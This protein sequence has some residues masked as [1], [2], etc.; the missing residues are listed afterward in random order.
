LIPLRTKIELDVSDVSVQKGEFVATQL[1]GAVDKAPITYK[2]LQELVHAGQNR[3]SWLIF[4][5]GIEHAEHIAEQ[6]GAFG[7]D[8]APVHSK[9]PSE[10][11]D[12]AIKAFKSNELRAIVNYGKLTTGFNHPKIDLIGMLRPTLSVPLWVQML[13]RGTRLADGKDNCLVMDFARNTPRL[14]CI[15]D[16]RI[17]NKKGNKEGE[18]PIKICE[19]CGAYN[20]ISVRFCCQ[21]NEPFTFQ[22]KIISKAGT[23]ELIKAAV[24]EPT[25]IIETFSVLNAIY[26]KHQ[27]RFGKPPTLKTTYFTTGLAFKEYI[28]LEHNGMAGK[29]AR[30][31]WRRRSPLEPPK[32]VDEALEHLAKL[33]CP[34][35]IRVHVNKS[36]PEI[37]NA[38]F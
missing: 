7:I 5:S 35:F 24:T 30:D 14:G 31:W 10:Y 25:P 2:A 16:P 17:P 33:R 29:V 13:F 27:G 6:L 28:C 12:A 20:H 32:T 19:N 38:E 18:T 37:L 8:C 36:F 4:A 34:R 26:E 11:N 15:N 3:K 9:R 21:C 23:D 22:V 1:Q